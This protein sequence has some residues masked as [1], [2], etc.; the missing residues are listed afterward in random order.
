MFFTPV[1]PF[2]PAAAYTDY[3]AVDFD[4]TNDYARRG[5]AMTGAANGR[6]GIFNTWFRLG[7]GDGTFMAFIT[8]SVLGV[9]NPIQFR[10]NSSDL[11][12]LNVI[13]AANTF[14]LGFT[15]TAAYTSGSGWHNLL[16]SWDTNFSA[17]NKLF[18]V[19]IDGVQDVGSITD[20]G[21]AFDIGY[22]TANDWIIGAT[23]T[24]S[25]LLNSCLMDMYLNTVTYMD[26]TQASNLAKFYNAGK[27]VYLGANG[28]APT[29]SQPL[30]YWHIGTGGTADNWVTNLGSGGGMTLTGALTLCSDKP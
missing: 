1:M 6:Q 3:D 28:S 19:M 21:I 17:G 11:I 30:G 5:A 29:G 7:G 8:G 23:S 15:S 20:A 10:R 27:P 2:L 13:D 24:P 25:Q 26:V 22:G 18:K 14:V 12:S 4:G 16:A 9:A